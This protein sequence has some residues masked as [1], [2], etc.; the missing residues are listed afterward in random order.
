MMS[1]RYILLFILIGFL[2]IFQ[3]C[4][5]MFG[6]FLD[7]EPSSQLTPEEV[8]EDFDQMEF[9]HLN[10]YS[11]LGNNLNYINSSWIDAAS[12]LG[13][14]SYFWGGTNLSLNVGNYFSSSGAQETI[15]PWAHYYRGIKKVNKYLEVI[16]DVPLL[17]DETVESRNEVVSRRNAEARFL[18]AVFYWELVIRY[19]GVPIIT[20]TLDLTDNLMIPRN[21]L[22]ECVSFILAEL[23]DVEKLLPDKNGI[24]AAGG[25]DAQYK[26]GRANQQM[27]M[28]MKSR[29]LLYYAS[30]L[31]NP[32]NDVTRWERAEQAA[33]DIMSLGYYSLNSSY[34]RLFSNNFSPGDS[35]EIIFY[36]N[37]PTG[38]WWREESPVGY[39]GYGGLCP[40]QELV[41]MFGMANGK[42]ITDPE[43][44][45]DPQYPYI[46]RDSRFYDCVLYNGATWWN[47]PIETFEGGKDKPNGNINA[48]PTGYY[49]RKYKDDKS[50][51]YLRNTQMYR[52]WVYI[53]YAE[54]LLNRAEARNEILSAPDETVYEMIEMV[55]TRAKITNPLPRTHTKEQMRELIRTERAVEFCFEGHRWWDIKR[56]RTAHEVLNKAIHGMHIVQNSDGSFSYEVVKVEE[57]VFLEH[58]YWYP[59]PET[60]IQKNPD[61]ENNPGW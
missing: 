12:D 37:N 52:N 13:E 15:N 27:A 57:R 45:Y 58:M 61:L 35:P 29:V 49:S 7:R 51:N 41:D 55:R 48:T 20:K 9:Y 43:S 42:S 60:E 36:R 34:N 14:T 4:E 22:D 31:F 30:P 46:N 1:K 5:D 2:F 56:W 3:A 6:D 33:I 50:T 25:T 10:I 26:Q 53:R 28:A 54:I 59:I 11:Y 21:T 23:E 47:M 39:G 8:L 24:T 17:P 16:P 38:N 44:G 18:R 40:T 32:D 19:G